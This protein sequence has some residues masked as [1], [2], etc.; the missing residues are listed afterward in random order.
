MGG[1]DRVPAMRALYVKNSLA[2]LPAV[3]SSCKQARTSETESDGA[4]KP[5]WRARLLA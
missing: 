2:T 4:E 1:A 5:V 3:A